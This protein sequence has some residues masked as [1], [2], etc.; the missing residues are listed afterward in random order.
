V[1]IER[2]HRAGIPHEGLTVLV[3]NGTHPIVGSRR[4]AELTG[5]LPDGV[6]TI[7]HSSREAGGL[8]EV[9]ELRSGQPLRF[10][11]AAVEAD[12]LLTIGSVRHHYFAGFGGGPK[13]VFP[14]VAGYE[15]IQANHRRVVRALGEKW[16][17]DPG[18]EPGVLDGNPVAEEILRAAKE[19]EPDMAVCLVPGSGGGFAWAGAGPWQSA[20]ETAVGKV[21]DW[22]EIPGGR[23][24]DF[25]VAGGG[26]R[27]SDST[28][29]QGH[30]ALDAASR[31]LTPGGELLWVARLDEG[32]GS[33]DMQSFVDDPRPT[34]ILDHLAKAWV[35]Y[36]HTTLRLV[37]KTSRFRVGLFSAMETETAESLGFNTVSDP[38]EV[39]ARWRRDFPG[40]T[41]GVMAGS[42]V[43]P[44]S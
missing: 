28:L 27:P 5:E 33:Q 44:R 10:N 14:G 11:R 17:R 23:S 22:F 32:L 13:M 37:E 38:E 34:A 7:E 1:V 40:A 8:V 15:E 41:V 12:L 18:C 16:E 25:M 6:K 3:A 36:G 35:Q 4:I 9:G 21:R 26:G 39:L 29:I 20:F 2:L 43:F 30:K 31:F 24:F 19:L 42:S